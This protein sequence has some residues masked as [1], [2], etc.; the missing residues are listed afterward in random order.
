[1]QSYITELIIIMIFYIISS[2]LAFF[3]RR[4]FRH[5]PIEIDNLIVDMDRTLLTTNMG[6]EALIA[7]CGQ[8]RADNI[9][10][11]VMRRV[12]NGNITMGEAML[13]ANN[14]LVEGNFNI[15]TYEK[16]SARCFSGELVRHD[17]L[18]SILKVQEKGKRIIVATMSSQEVAKT[19]AEKYG[20]F[21][22]LGTVVN[23]DSTGKMTGCSQIICEENKDVNGVRF[24]TKISVLEELFKSKN[25]EFDPGRTAVITDDI[26]DLYIMRN[27]ALGIFLI[28]KKPTKIQKLCYRLK[29][30]D[31]A[32]SED[33]ELDKII[34]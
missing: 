14:Y 19:L 28:L 13:I 25:L 26:T 7:C 6:K 33:E 27:V 32:I 34:K 8:E 17:L 10:H 4:N 31:V 16:L 12:A 23:Y 18:K 3:F 9:E 21:G 2:S 5:K 22:A 20:F 1:M 24:R 29:L 11:G 30:F 15:H